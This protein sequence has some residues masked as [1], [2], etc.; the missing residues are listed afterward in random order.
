MSQARR[1]AAGSFP[2]EEPAVNTIA[3]TRA[4]DDLILELLEWL[5]RDPHPY[6]EALDVWRTSCPRQPV[7]EDANDRG[8]IA[9]HRTPGGSALIGLSPAGVEHLRK[10]RKTAV[11]LNTTSPSNEDDRRF[12][13]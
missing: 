6:K 1:R 12:R 13:R 7:W 2:A 3:A 5:G 4:M 10:H 9:R 11:S 8:F